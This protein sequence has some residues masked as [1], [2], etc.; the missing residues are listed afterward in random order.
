MESRSAGAEKGDIMA[1]LQ[2]VFN[3]FR[4]TY[5]ADERAV[6]LLVLSLFLSI[7]LTAACAVAT[8]VYILVTGKL[9]G[10][11]FGGKG[12]GYLVLFCAVMLL[13]TA[14]YGHEFELLIAI[15]VLLLLILAL[16]MRRVMTQR[17]FQD[18]IDAACLMSIGAF[19]VALLQKLLIRENQFDNRFEAVF[20]NPNYYAAIIEMVVLFALYKMLTQKSG[21][22]FY[23]FVIAF[24]FSGLAICQCRTA[25]LVIACSVPCL[26]LFLGRKKLLLLYIALG[27]CGAGLLFYDPGL[28]PRAEALGDDFDTRWSIWMAAIE[29]FFEHPLLGGG[30]YTYSRIYTLYGGASTTHAHNLLLELLLNYG[31]LGTGAAIAYVG[32]T[33]RQVIRHYMARRNRSACA[34]CLAILIGVLAHGAVDA[35][36]FWP[37]TG[38]LAAAIFACPGICES[39]KWA[40]SPSSRMPSLHLDLPESAM[41][42]QDFPEQ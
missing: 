23:T 9:R 42:F 17:L 10:T 14:A 15:G 8:I 2:A 19:L 3:R 32:S 31:L 21:R 18:L 26:L 40:A 33:T 39:K 5:S 20:V 7:Y 30:C 25:F 13:T 24:N 22:L 12:A 1:N 35:T 36:L 4:N 37:Q 41:L 28:F 29:G 6:F 11:L 16:F 38:L 27:I 34:L